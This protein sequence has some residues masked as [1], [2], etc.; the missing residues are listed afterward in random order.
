LKIYSCISA[1]NQYINVTF[2]IILIKITVYF[3]ISN[4]L[5][6]FVL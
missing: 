4:Q 2:V 6:S 3:F 5:I 1:L